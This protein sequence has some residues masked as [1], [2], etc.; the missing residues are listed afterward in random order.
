MPHGIEE[1]HDPEFDARTLV[2]AKVIRG[3]AKRKKA[4]I[5]W[6]KKDQTAKAAVIKEGSKK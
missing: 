5:A 1:H 3:N 6:L 4:A 2:N